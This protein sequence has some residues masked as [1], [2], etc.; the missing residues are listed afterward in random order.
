MCCLSSLSKYYFP[1]WEDDEILALREHAFPSQDPSE[2]IERLQTWGGVPRNVLTHPESDWQNE[3]RRAADST[4]VNMLQHMQSVDALSEGQLSNRIFLIK[5]KAQNPDADVALR[6][7]D[8]EFYSFWRMEVCSNEIA[9]RLV[10]HFV[11]FSA[12]QSR[13]FA[14]QFQSH[15][16]TSALAGMMIEAL[17]RDELCGGGM[18]EVRRLFP[19]GASTLAAPESSAQHELQTFSIEQLAN[20]SVELPDHFAVIM[21]VSAQRTFS[22]LKQLMTGHAVSRSQL[23]YSTN[24]NLTGFDFVLPGSI[25]ANVTINSSHPLILSGET[26]SGI[27]EA[28]QYLC[29][30]DHEPRKLTSISE[31]HRIGVKYVSSMCTHQLLVHPSQTFFR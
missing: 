25:L 13:H 22:K 27:V 7:S 21:P 19:T 26:N 4:D 14:A 8:H 5:T 12:A 15:P 20:S 30:P 31:L 23:M 28:W 3:L 11:M 24:P 10:K 18:F 29:N 6:A 1:L 2:V 17:A 16:N 9:A